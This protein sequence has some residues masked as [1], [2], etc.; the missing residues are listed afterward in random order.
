MFLQLKFYFYRL[1]QLHLLSFDRVGEF[2]DASFFGKEAIE[3][4]SSGFWRYIR[5]IVNDKKLGISV[6]NI[7]ITNLCKCN[8]Y[9]YASN[10]PNKEIT[11]DFYYQ[12]CFGIFKRE[13]E[14]IKPSHIIF[15]TSAYFDDI[16]E[17]LDLR[18]F[19]DSK[20]VENTRMRVKKENGKISKFKPPKKSKR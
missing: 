17:K 6:E 8:I 16:I 13:I 4:H 3:G 7:A 2:F 19:D 1:Q 18:L 12:K 9:D 14:I 20:L 15:F 11:P 10:E 5:D